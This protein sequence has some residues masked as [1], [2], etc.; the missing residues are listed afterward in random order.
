MMATTT[1]PSTVH[2]LQLSQV[3]QGIH[4]LLVR[5]MPRLRTWP[6]RHRTQRDL[7]S[8]NDRLL[9]DIGISRAEAEREASEPLQKHYVLCAWLAW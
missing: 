8:L 7:L 6:Q 9:R 1:H 5:G 4:A 3:W 2:N